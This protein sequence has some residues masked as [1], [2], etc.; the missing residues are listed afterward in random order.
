MWERSCR[1]LLGGW[2]SKLAAALTNPAKPGPTPQGAESN[3]V[4]QGPN[5]CQRLREPRAARYI[6][7]S[8]SY[9]NDGQHE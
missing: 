6:R 3:I 2:V 1:R 8:C 7:G 9:D 4:S 5:G